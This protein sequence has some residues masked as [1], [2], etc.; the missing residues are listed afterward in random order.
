MRSHRGDDVT[1]TKT[2]MKTWP[3][4]QS[5]SLSLSPPPH[6]S[7]T[8]RQMAALID[9][10]KPSLW[11]MPG[12]RPPPHS[13]PAPYTLPHE[14][15]ADATSSH[16]AVSAASIVFNPTFWK[17]VSPALHPGIPPLYV[18]RFLLTRC[19]RSIAARQGAF[20]VRT[21]PASTYAAAARDTGFHTPRL[22]LTPACHALQ[23]IETRR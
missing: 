14:P 22:S 23:S 6:Q 10:S 1:L 15:L 7:A 3:Y 19:F 4:T 12:P 5:L 20:D 2:P 13:P 9:F 18:G 11:G 16:P 21:R 17:C 8:P